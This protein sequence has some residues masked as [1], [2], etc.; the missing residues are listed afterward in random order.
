MTGRNLKIASTGLIGILL[1]ALFY[2][3]LRW[4]VGEWLGNDYYSHGPLVP[5]ISAFLAWRLW[6]KWPPEQRRLKPGDPGCCRSA[7]GWPSTVCAAAA[8]LL[9]RLPGHD[10]HPGGAG[11]VP[12]GRS[13]ARAVGFPLGFLLL[14]CRCRLSSR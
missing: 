10:R 2:P 3:T 9:R 12:V 13:R 5:L 14:W 11:L 8:G 4:L 1:L 7:P 6:L